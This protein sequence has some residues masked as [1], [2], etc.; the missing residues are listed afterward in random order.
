[1]ANKI[2]TPL[3]TAIRK[4]LKDQAD[5]ERAVPMAAYLKNI[6]SCLGVPATPVR[7]IVR[8]CAKSNPPQQAAELAHAIREL[9]EGEHREERYAAIRLAQ[10]FARLAGPDFL[11]LYEWMVVK[12]QWWDLVDTIASDL[13]GP[14]M[15]KYPE[16]KKPVFAFIESDNM[17]LRRTALLSQLKYKTQTDREILARL[18]L[19]TAHEKEFFIRKAIGW[20][21]REF[22][23]TDPEWVRSFVREY[24]SKL[25]PLSIREALK[26]IG[27]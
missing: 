1:M 24:K 9:W 18:I 6:Q 15:D 7:E 19:A 4:A 10:R 22:A 11:E 27:E 25:A 21:L 2:H 14:L 23:K 12:G 26:N 8:E 13:V 17:W 16:L 3:T 20:V 5:P